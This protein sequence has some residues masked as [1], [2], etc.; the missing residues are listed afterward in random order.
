MFYMFRLFMSDNL[1]LHSAPFVASIFAYEVNWKPY[2]LWSLYYLWKCQSQSN[3][4]I[5]QTQRNSDARY[6]GRSLRT[7]IC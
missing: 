4:C 2:L 1:I 7:G 3:L 5:H 6:V